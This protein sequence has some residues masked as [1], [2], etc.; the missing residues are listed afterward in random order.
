MNWY[1]QYLPEAKKD[2][3]EFDKN[4]KIAVLSAVKKVSTNPV[5]YT[6]GGYGKP[7]GKKRQSDL[8][9]FL[10]IKLL[11]Y[12][13]RVVYKLIRTET[14]MLIVVI[15]ARKDDQVYKLA[16]KRIEKHGL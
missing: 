3:A 5:P 4:I 7:L 10:K 8:T 11:K 15:G 6:E 9:G 2:L 13:I 12:G 14:E 16:A 1:V